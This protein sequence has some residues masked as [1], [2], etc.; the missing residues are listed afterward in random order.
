PA[1]DPELNA[2]SSDPF[3][4]DPGA[5][6][7]DNGYLVDSRGA[8]PTPTSPAASAP[9]VTPPVQPLPPSGGAQPAFSPISTPPPADD[10]GSAQAALQAAYAARATGTPFLVI[11]ARMEPS[12]PEAGQFPAVLEGLR[13]ALPAGGAFFADAARLR[14][15]LVL[16][17]ATQDAAAGVFSTLQQHLQSALGAQAEGTLRAVAAI[18]VP[19]GEPF[20]SAQELWTYAVAS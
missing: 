13:K 19:N 2:P 12:Q 20:G 18:T 7:F 15:I 3:G 14:S 5:K 10:A 8:T 6:F 16:P 17:G 11:A 1:P 9:D 4:Q